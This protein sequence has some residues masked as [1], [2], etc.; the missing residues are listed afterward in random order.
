MSLW[1]TWKEIND[2]IDRK[3]AAALDP[4]LGQDAPEWYAHERATGHYGDVRRRPQVIETR[5]AEQIRRDREQS[6]GVDQ[7][8]E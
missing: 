2:L 3:I 8:P 4:D 1:P 6:T 5:T 7:T